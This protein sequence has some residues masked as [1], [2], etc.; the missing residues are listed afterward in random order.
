MGFLAL[1]L[2]GS[3]GFSELGVLIAIG[4]LFAGF[5]MCTVLFL[6]IRE[7]QTAIGATT[8]SFEAVKRYVCWAVRKPK[9]ASRCRS[10]RC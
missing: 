7:R 4:I 8:G 10:A 2:S 9:P 5:F 3:L 1:I 6:F